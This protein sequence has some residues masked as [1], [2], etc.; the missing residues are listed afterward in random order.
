[1]GMHLAPDSLTCTGITKKNVAYIENKFERYRLV[2]CKYQITG[3]INR[4][5]LYSGTSLYSR[6]LNHVVKICKILYE[7]IPQMC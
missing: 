2:I 3:L 4:N 7:N 5:I 6:G 1:M